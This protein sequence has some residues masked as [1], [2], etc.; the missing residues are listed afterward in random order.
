MANPKST[1]RLRLEQLVADG[2]WHRRDQLI[3]ELVG[4]VP[5]GKATRHAAAM[6][7][8]VITHPHQV[9]RRDPIQ[10]GSRDIVRKTIEAAAARGFLERTVVDGAVSYRKARR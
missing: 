10:V 6:R 4:L 3:A 9:R 1:V 8:S 2:E 7:Q 5:P